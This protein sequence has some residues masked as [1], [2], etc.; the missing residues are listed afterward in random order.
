MRRHVR[1]RYRKHGK[2]A[3][4]GALVF[5]LILAAVV[6]P[7]ASGGT[8]GGRPAAYTFTGNAAACAGQ[9][10]VAFPVVVTNMSKTQ[11]LGSADL[12]A[13]LNI[14]VTGAT[15]TAGGGSGI[16]VTPIGPAP[17][18]PPGF[19]QN[20]HPS[21]ISLRSLQVP[22]TTPPSSVTVSDGERER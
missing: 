17:S 3:W 14:T 2:V 9:S 15:I 6:I 8:S 18:T 21:L 22:G 13:P 1:T 20:T 16:V 4:G 19:P 11:N 12:Y 10:S 5:A 7:L